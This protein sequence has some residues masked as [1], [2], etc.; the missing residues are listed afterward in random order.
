MEEIHTRDFKEINDNN[1]KTNEYIIRHFYNGYKKIRVKFN[2]EKIPV[3][4]WFND[5]LDTD[6]EI[7]VEPKKKVTKRYLKIHDIDE[8]RFKTR[9]LKQVDLLEANL[10]NKELIL[11]LLKEI[12]LI[13]PLQL[14]QSIYTILK[15][16]ITD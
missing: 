10:T 6:F 9:N 5:F 3:K 15:D 1:E 8:T 2:T 4:M 12:K 14:K 13:N 16:M 11:E 7:I